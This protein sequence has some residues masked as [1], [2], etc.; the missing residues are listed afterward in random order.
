M[1]NLFFN[2]LSTIFPT[3]TPYHCRCNMRYPL[4]SHGRGRSFC[5]TYSC[6]CALSICKI[7]SVHCEPKTSQKECSGL[8]SCDHAHLSIL[9]PTLSNAIMPCIVRNI[10]EVT[11]TCF[12]VRTKRYFSVS[13]T[14][15]KVCSK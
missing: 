7:F 11:Y 4:G 14:N 1:T 15:P 12:G 2:T 8:Q 13:I 9:T 5:A 10:G 6:T 3:H